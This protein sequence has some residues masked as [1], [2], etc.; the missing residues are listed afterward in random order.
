MASIS[1]GKARF[2]CQQL[3]RCLGT[4]LTAIERSDVERVSP[5]DSML[6]SP[7][8]GRGHAV[9]FASSPAPCSAQPCASSLRLLPCLSSSQT[10]RLDRRRRAMRDSRQPRSG[11][12]QPREVITLE[13]SVDTNAVA[14]LAAGPVA[15]QLQ[16]RCLVQQN[17][18]R[19]HGTTAHCAEF[20]SPVQSTS[21][22][23]RGGAVTPQV[24]RP[25][26]SLVRSR[27]SCNSELC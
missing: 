13:T 16:S 2:G 3:L 27:A 22:V 25:S 15:D 14:W 9:T 18:R 12:G 17:P 4:E 24:S 10:L 19:A 21:Q 11:A 7:C 26:Q 8:R 23:R 1:V 6:V 5:F 20:Q